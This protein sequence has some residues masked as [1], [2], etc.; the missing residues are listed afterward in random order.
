M[1]HIPSSIDR[2]LT[3]L[4]FDGLRPLTVYVEVVL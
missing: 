1:P 2:L 3:D 4:I